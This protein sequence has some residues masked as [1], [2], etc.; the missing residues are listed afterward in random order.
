MK[1]VERTILLAD[2]DGLGAKPRP[3]LIAPVLGH[4]RVTL[5]DSVRMGFLHASRSRGRAP[6]FI[7]AA[8]DV[9]FVSHSASAEGGTLLRFEVPP[10]G[11]VADHIFRQTKLWDDGPKPGQTA[12]E[13]LGAA[14]GDVS[15]HRLDSSRFDTG[16]LQ[17][18]GSYS[19]VLNKGIGRI[20]LI[21]VDLPGSTQIDDGI[22]KSA[23]ELVAVT[24]PV[25]RIRV[26]GRLDLMGASQGIL[27]IHLQRG[28]V[29]T[30][31]WFGTEPVEKLKEFFSRDVTVEGEGV[32]RPSGSLLRIDADAVAP[33]SKQDEFFRQLPHAVAERDN[34]NQAR[35]RVGEKS[36]YPQILGSIPGEESDEDFAMAVEEMS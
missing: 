3:E 27:K 35:L 16:L 17:R 30:A 33:A 13:L 10:F 22:V 23:A 6:E 12:F 8:A 18:I 32:F 29:V 1:R 4:L 28:A 20:Q 24:P 2:G 7:G 21:D 11:E 31:L 34:V 19:R 14:I 25:R 5:V 36:A 9:R 26:T 15:A